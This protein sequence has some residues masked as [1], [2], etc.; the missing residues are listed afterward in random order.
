[1]VHFPDYIGRILQLGK[2]I[3]ATGWCFLILGIMVEQELLLY[4]FRENKKK[5]KTTEVSLAVKALVLKQH[6]GKPQW[7]RTPG[8]PQPRCRG[9]STSRLQGPLST[10]HLSSWGQGSA[11]I[12]PSTLGFWLLRDTFLK[13]GRG[14]GGYGHLFC[15]SSLQNTFSRGSEEAAELAVALVFFSHLRLRTSLKPT[16]Q[17]IWLGWQAIQDPFISTLN[18][19]NQLFLYGIPHRLGLLYWPLAR[20]QRKKEKKK[21]MVEAFGV[22]ST[23]VPKGGGSC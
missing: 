3:Q 22:V 18:P 5:K 2:V 10:S 1:M 17:A 7:R 19:H 16:A 12:W 9:N 6:Q 23:A 14:A 20:K 13:S 21:L 4:S 8:I 15:G 11:V